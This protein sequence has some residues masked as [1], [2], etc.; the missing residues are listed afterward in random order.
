MSTYEQGHGPTPTDYTYA[1]QYAED[2][3]EKQ[4]CLAQ[5]DKYTWIPSATTRYPCPEGL[6]C[7][8]GVCKFKQDAC[9]QLSSLPYYDCERRTVECDTHPS[10]QCQVCDYSISLGRKI[11]GP[12][13]DDA[14]SGCDAGDYKYSQ[15][16]EHPTP[17]TTPG[18]SL[19]GFC[20]HDE[21]CAQGVCVGPEPDEVVERWGA[22][23]TTAQDCGGGR[24][25]CAQGHCVSDTSYEGMCVVPC[26]ASTDCAHLDPLAQCGQDPADA[27]L[28]GRCFIPPQPNDTPKLC[29]PPVP[30]HAPYTVDMYEGDQV[31][32]KPVPCEVDQHCWF[33]PGVGGVCG[34]DPA[35]PTYGYCYDPSSPPYLEWKDEMRLWDGV[36]PSKNV[37]I[38]TDPT[39]R[40]W[41]E[42][43]W[44]RPGTDDEDFTHP[45]Q[46]RVK[47]AWKEKARPPFMYDERDGTCHVTRTYCT[48]NLKDGGF[49]AG[50][51]RSTN[52]WLGSTCSGDTKGEVVG[53]YE[54]CTKL[55][56]SIGEFFL[57]RTLT[58]D[59][60]ELVEGD[61]EGFGQRWGNYMDRLAEQTGLHPGP[62]KVVVSNEDLLREG[63]PGL[64]KV[65]EF[66]CDPRLKSGIRR[67]AANVLPGGV[68]G[69]EWT[70]NEAAKRLYGFRG[71]ATG[72]LTTE[73]H[74]V[75]PHLVK[76]TT[77]GYQHIEISPAT[78]DES[79]KILDAMVFLN[80]FY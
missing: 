31:V 6:E 3:M 24:S 62:D 56:D 80:K 16:P 64:A 5:P 45:L 34:R 26:T 10:G 23:C 14:P 70:W 35:L 12:F 30:D 54:C 49:S 59:F 63:N 78:D 58:T 74:Q 37:C 68:H 9:K 41:C 69:Y 22:A 67:I 7:E 21:Q 48:A 25:V 75:Y 57:G 51:G 1:S 42:M 11:H 46:R 13:S 8:S 50:Y 27:S 18:L 15:Q 36:P 39:A 61:V 17:Y 72:L 20:N 29:Q 76:T 52:Y 32:S 28:Y 47:D 4:A 77:Q 19:S 53:A 33:P 38:E 55:G 43:P 40:R 60:R 79:R 2:V 44:T 71:R 66:V 73:V 65:I